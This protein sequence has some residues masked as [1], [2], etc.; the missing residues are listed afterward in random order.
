M[1]RMYR[2]TRRSACMR[3][4]TKSAALSW[5]CWTGCASLLRR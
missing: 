5:S 2:F 1:Q 4:K 3:R